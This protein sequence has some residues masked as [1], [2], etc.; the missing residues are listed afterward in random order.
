MCVY[1]TIELSLNIMREC[2]LSNGL[3]LA[4]TAL[5][6]KVV[7]CCLD[8]VQVSALLCE[9]LADWCTENG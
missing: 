5:A 9:R 3:L 8:I 7:N 2:F 6:A 1:Y 4:L